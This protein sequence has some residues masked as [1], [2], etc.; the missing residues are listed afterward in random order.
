MDEIAES[1]ELSKGT[2]YLYFKNKEELILSLLIV[3]LDT[4]RKI[5]E[6]NLKKQDTFQSRFSCIGESYLE[7]YHKYPYQFK[8]MNHVPD[9]HPEIEHNARELE[10]ELMA[11]STKLWSTV[12]GVIREGIDIGLIR[13]DVNPLEIG[14]ALWASSNGMIQLMEHIK[15]DMKRCMDEN[16]CLPEGNKYAPQFMTMDFEKMLRSL[17]EAVNNSILVKPNYNVS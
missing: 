2:L 9:H 17:W 6:H 16:G 5:M 8:I 3:T 13:K 11:S 15:A 14:I 12:E 1:S 4:F 7:F 10:S